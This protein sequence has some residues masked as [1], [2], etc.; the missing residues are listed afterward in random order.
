MIFFIE[1]TP[2]PQ[3]RPRG[4]KGRHGVFSP[5]TEWK[6]SV[7]YNGKQW[8]VKFSG[9]LR[10]NMVFMFH[11]PKSHYGTGKNATKR[12]DSAPKYM[13]SKPDLDNLAKAVLDALQDV[14]VI[15]DDSAVIELN[16]RK[17]YVS[18]HDDAQ[19]MRIEIV[20]LEKNNEQ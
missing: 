10:V 7:K 18:R 3:A 5:T 2:K 13:T 19:G 9:S 6:E 11:R 14:N 8:G 16:L 1:G 4:F 17:N 15:K 12:K 20:E